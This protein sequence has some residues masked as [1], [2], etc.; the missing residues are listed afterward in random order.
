MNRTAKRALGIFA[1]K[2]QPGRVKTRL[3]PPLS[4][5]QAA[6]LYEVSLR[7]TITVMAHG[8]FDL[9]LF[10]ADGTD[11]FAK[12]FPH[13]HRAPQ[14]GEDLGARMAN[15]L[16][17]LLK[18]Y[19]SAALI[20]SD[21]PDLPLALVGRAFSALDF[22]DPVIIPSC[23]GGYVLLGESSHHP[24]LFRGM[25]WSTP[26]VLEQTRRRAA[27]RAIA[28]REVG[29]W[30]DLDDLPSLK[31]LVQR[32]PSSKTAAFARTHLGDLL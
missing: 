20:G 17:Q 8:D 11:W 4:P 26:D 13:L 5:E 32:S 30:E 22:G 24:D 7:E 18:Q 31:R 2:P 10:H 3:C 19:E 27:E 23:D 29:Q 21:S 15:A 1:K 12:S 14:R 25:P 6:A 16:E 9:V 28:L